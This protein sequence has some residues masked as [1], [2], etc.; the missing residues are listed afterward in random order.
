MD[1]W[2]QLHTTRAP[3]VKFQ[4][5]VN[6]RAFIYPFSFITGSKSQNSRHITTWYYQGQLP[7]NSSEV[8]SILISVI[9]WIRT[10]HL[11]QRICISSGSSRLSLHT[12]HTVESK[13][14]N[15]NVERI[16]WDE[17]R[18]CVTRWVVIVDT[19]GQRAS[20]AA[21]WHWLASNH[22]TS[23]AHRQC[24]VGDYQL[25]FCLVFS[26]ICRKWGLMSISY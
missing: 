10:L 24:L 15:G 7:C 14:V 19:S 20:F 25:I 1:L 22:R 8:V 9:M 13:G 16:K 6:K 11:S 4:R 17:S 12:K 23:N 5:R 21:V 26:S 2:L 18:I 3:A